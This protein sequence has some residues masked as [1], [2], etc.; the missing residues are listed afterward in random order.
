MR[1][2]IQFAAQL[3]KQWCG[4]T[5]EDLRIK[6]KRADT[7]IVFESVRATGGRRIM[8]ILPPQQNLWVDSGSGSRPSV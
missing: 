8:V 7:G 2:L 5:L 4:K 3:A 1:D 6:A